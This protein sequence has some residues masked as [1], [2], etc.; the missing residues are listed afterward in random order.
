[1]TEQISSGYHY[2]VAVIVQKADTVRRSH[3]H[4]P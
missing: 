4:D 2:T 3:R 1:M